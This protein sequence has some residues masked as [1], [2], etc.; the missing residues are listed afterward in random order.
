[1]LLTH[2][3]VA[4]GKCMHMTGAPALWHSPALSHDKAYAPPTVMHKPEPVTVL[5]L[6]S[7]HT[8]T[9]DSEPVN[10]SIRTPLDLLAR[11]EMLMPGEYSAETMRIIHASLS[12]RIRSKL[13]EDQ[14]RVA[15]SEVMALFAAL[16]F[17]LCKTVL[18]PWAGNPAVSKAFRQQGVKIVTNDPWSNA[19]DLAH[20][21]LDTHL[22]T[23]VEGKMNLNAVAMIPPVLLSDICP[24]HSFLPCGLL[25]VY[26]CP[27]LVA[28]SCTR[29][30]LEHHHGSHSFT[31]IHGHHNIKQ[32]CILLG[33]LLQT[34]HGIQ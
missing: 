34:S 24:C 14:P 1:M 10:W 28:H 15:P 16:D 23:S 4:S 32:P 3:L 22:Y 2:Q 11:M 25:C 29:I 31:N 26:V 5:A 17:N 9:V 6:R 8:D 20:E 33:M 21:P 30:T 12:Q 7:C 18:D 27:C 19:T 13:V